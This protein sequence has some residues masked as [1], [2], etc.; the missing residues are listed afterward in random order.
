M[1]INKKERSVTP[2]VLLAGI[3]GALLIGLLIAPSAVADR[4]AGAFDVVVVSDDINKTV[5]TTA[6]AGD[7]G[8]DGDAG[9]GNG[10]NGHGN[11][12]DGVDSSNPGQGGGG[13]N[14]GDDPSGTYDDEG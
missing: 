9:S 6:R 4:S 10:N 1:Y 3:G 8:D 2:G 12:L 7:D 13:P 5:T 11:N 14:G